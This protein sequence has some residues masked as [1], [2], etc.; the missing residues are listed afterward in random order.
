[1][2]YSVPPHPRPLSVY[3]VM[4]PEGKL[5]QPN[6]FFWILPRPA[7]IHVLDI[8]PPLTDAPGYIIIYRW[9]R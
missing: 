1:M 6:I 8:Y 3:V 7:S 9:K 2:A 4:E 5:R